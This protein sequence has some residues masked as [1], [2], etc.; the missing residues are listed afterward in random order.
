M[1]ETEELLSFLTMVGAIHAFAFTLGGLLNIDGQ[2]LIHP[3]KLQEFECDEISDLLNACIGLKESSDQIPADIRAQADKIASKHRV[4]FQ[5]QRNEAISKILS[6]FGCS[7]IVDIHIGGNRIFSDINTY[8]TDRLATVLGS[9]AKFDKNIITGI[10]IWAEY[11]LC[12]SPREF[13]CY[14]EYFCAYVKD[15]IKKTGIRL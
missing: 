4:K 3:L 2:I 15:E 10:V 14:V 12:S 6:I 5:C 8:Q 7:D 9:T 11:R 1:F 13:C